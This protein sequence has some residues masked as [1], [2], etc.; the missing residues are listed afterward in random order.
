MHRFKF[1]A[2]AIMSELDIEFSL[3]Y[4]ESTEVVVL[5]SSNF[6]H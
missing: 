3:S 2:P 5:N 1:F 4:P 6:Q